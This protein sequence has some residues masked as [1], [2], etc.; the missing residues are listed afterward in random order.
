MDNRMLIPL[1]I[2]CVAG[3]LVLLALRFVTP[4]TTATTAPND[5][6]KISDI[7]GMSIEHKGIPYTLNFDQQNHVVSFLN[8]AIPVSKT[9]FQNIHETL[10]FSKLVI[11]TFNG[12][13][14]EVN[15][16]GYW[17][18]NLVFFAP[19]WNQSSYLIEISG[20]Q[21]KDTLAQSYDP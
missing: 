18:N 17:E 12:P 16:I 8:D 2:L 13:D 15:P 11:Y 20:G 3:F 10:P 5:Y 7:R 6:V 21:L 19:A 14:I 4:A 1:T 9:N